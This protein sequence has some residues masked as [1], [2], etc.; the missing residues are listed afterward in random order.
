MC[1]IIT[2]LLNQMKLIEVH[3]LGEIECKRPGRNP[4]RGRLSNLKILTT[5]FQDGPLPLYFFGFFAE[6]AFGW[7]TSRP[8]P[9]SLFRT[10]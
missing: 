7:I 10:L 6:G 5:S 1:M 2:S 4:H 3:G 9:I 8:M